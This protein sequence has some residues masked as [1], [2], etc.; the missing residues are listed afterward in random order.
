MTKIINEPKSI[1]E[2]N[3]VIDPDFSSNALEV[4]KKRYLAKDE[5]GKIIETPKEM[6]I[7]V[8]TA[9]AEAETDEGTKHM[10]ATVFY[11]MMANRVF[12]PNSPTIMN[13]G[14]R[15][16]ML[17]ACFVLPVED[18]IDSIFDS[19]KAT[20]LVQKAGGGTGFSFNDLRPNGSIVKSSG[21]TTAGPLSFIDVFSE[22]TSAIQ[23][24][25]FRRGAN[26]GI[27]KIDHP[28]IIE[29][30]KAKE[31]LSRWQNYNVSIS[32]TD[33]WMDALKEDPLNVHEVYHSEWGCGELWQKIDGDTGELTVKA[34]KST[35]EISYGWKHW[36]LEDTWALIC[37]RAWSTGEPGLFFKD[38][39]NAKNVLLDS[40]GP[41]EATNP[42]GE[43]PL[44]PYDSCTLGSIN[45]S[46]FHSPNEESD[47]DWDS[48]KSTVESAVRFLDNVVEVNNYPLP[49][50]MEM[51]KG[52]SRRIGLG[53][54]GWADLLFAMKIPYN[55]GEAR[56]FAER[57]QDFITVHAEKC[58]E[59]IAH[60]KGNFGGW[61]SSTYGKAD[62]PMRNAF[63]TTVAPTGT[64]SI[65]ADCS[66][67]IEP[68]YALSFKR[69]VM[70]DSSG[71]FTVMEE[72][73]PY[74]KEAVSKTTISNGIKTSLLEYAVNHGSIQ[75]F[76]TN[77]SEVEEL[78]KL[79]I[80]AHDIVPNDHIDMQAAWQ[81][82]VSTSISKTINLSKDSSSKDVQ[83]AYMRAYDGGCV[84]ITV[85]RDGCR[86]GKN[87]MKQPMKV[88]TTKIEKPENIAVSFD[89]NDDMLP[90]VRT[91]IKT[92]FGNLHVNIVRDKN[93]DKE[94]EIFAQLG[95]AGDLIAADI[96]AICRISSRLLHLGG[97]LN[98][99]IDQLEYIGTTHIMPSEHG[100]IT[101]MPDALAKCLKKYVNHKKHIDL[102][103]VTN[104]KERTESEYGVACPSCGVKLSFQEGCM[105]CQG[106]G[107]SAC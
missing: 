75:D 48:L 30:I 90:A 68:L 98:D 100:K 28:D 32:M 17:S 101:S 86:E 55:S 56:A 20:A 40:C 34:F 99:V 61:K 97:T 47:F 89:Y 50:I 106:C 22:A 24:G 62:R 73:N 35:E 92:Q 96:E 5:N 36:T 84:G 71:H 16:G 74:W 79:F 67:G 41:I 65:I 12:I 94:I 15:M 39:A 70:P 3:D 102:K 2:P 81:R 52:T 85:Y 1:L 76:E 66:G 42:C 103:K 27:L 64:I 91:K 26:M 7:R 95:K 13:A 51:S 10:W 4:L 33:D 44:H 43:Q 77:D 69:E 45:L 93:N 80:T 31:D 6:L 57:I 21:G 49:E 11:E 14:R 9:V 29:F 107:Y 25:A 72:H 37:Q 46:K 87:G 88:A 82:K 105:K 60:E 53:V 78:K 8:A 58:S 38:K 23:Q 54:M 63:H 104:G 19:I 18:N 83:N 59:E